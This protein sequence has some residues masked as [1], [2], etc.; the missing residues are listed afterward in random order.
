MTG[1]GRVTSLS[2]PR[3]SPTEDNMPKTSKP[4]PAPKGAKGGKSKKGY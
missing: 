4:K 1:R 3:W 2:L